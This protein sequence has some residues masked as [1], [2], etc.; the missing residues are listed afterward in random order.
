MS[1]RAGSAKRP[2]VASTTGPGR[3]PVRHGERTRRS[4][5]RF[6]CGRSARYKANDGDERQRASWSCAKQGVDRAM[7]KRVLMALEANW[8]R[9]T[10]DPTAQ[11]GAPDKST[12][13]T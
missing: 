3:S 6:I 4:N 2:D 12:P 8:L 9:S 13:Q 5:P 10:A 1:M 7:S 11:Q